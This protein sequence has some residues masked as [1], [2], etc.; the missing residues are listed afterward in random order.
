M[1]HSPTGKKDTEFIINGFW[2]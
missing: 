2:T 1:K